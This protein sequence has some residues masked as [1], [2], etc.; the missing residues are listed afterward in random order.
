MALGGGWPVEH[1]APMGSLAEGVYDL[2]VVGGGVVGLAVARAACALHPQRS[3][4]VLEKESGVGLHQSGRNSGVL[5][6]GIYYKPG[7]LKARLCRSG[8][9]RMEHYCREKGLPISPLGKVI[10]AVEE[11]ERGALRSLLERGRANGVE[12]ELVDRVRLREIEPHAAGLEAL[13]VPEAAVLDFGAVCRSLAA[14]LEASG[15][16]VLTGARVFACGPAGS[17]LVVR[18]SGGDVRARR[19]VNCAGLQSDRVAALAPGAGEPPARIVPFRGEYRMLAPRAADLVRGLIYPVPDP[20]F[21]FLGV[22]LTRGVDG[23]VECGPNAVLSL[24]REG[25][26]SRLPVLADM[27]D[28]LAW[29]GFRHLARRHLRTGLGEVWRSLCARAFANAVRRLLPELQDADLLPAP[30]GIRAQAVTRDG[31]LVDDFLFAEGPGALHVLNAPSPAA[32][33]S[34]AIGE[35]VARRLG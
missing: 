22:H 26:Q 19:L 2:A 20:A 29:P 23:R 7:S 11:N 16:R 14:D 3:V 8:R 35:E 18:T 33:A 31:A 30:C 13:H 15:Q 5:H 1:T 21:P 12:C 25:Y 17:E 24:A 10:V 9:A 4:V 27:L 34:L 32:T 28:T 6:T